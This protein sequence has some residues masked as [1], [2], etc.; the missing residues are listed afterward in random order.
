MKANA[1]KGV[2]DARPIEAKGAVDG[3]KTARAAGL[4]KK[5]V[6]FGRLSRGAGSFSVNAACTPP[7]P[8]PP[9]M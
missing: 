6:Y 8:R 2:C 1:C 3:A 5:K 7:A 9:C 4:G